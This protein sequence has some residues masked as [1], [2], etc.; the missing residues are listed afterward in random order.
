MLGLGDTAADVNLVA[1]GTME[2]LPLAQT[3]QIAPDAAEMKHLQYRACYRHGERPEEYYLR[4]I[5]TYALWAACSEGR[6]RSAR[7]RGYASWRECAVQCSLLWGS[8]RATAS[9][10][11]AAKCARGRPYF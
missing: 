4:L 10:P 8:R 11:S 9:W 5:L 6:S 3:I 1:V 7:P 2:R